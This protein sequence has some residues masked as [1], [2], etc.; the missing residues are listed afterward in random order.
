MREVEV[1]GGE[2]LDVVNVHVVYGEALAGAEVETA[3]DP[4]HFQVAVDLAALLERRRLVD[5]PFPVLATELR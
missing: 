2:G 3:A 4:V 1:G 5:K